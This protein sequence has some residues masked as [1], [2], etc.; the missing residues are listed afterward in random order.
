MRNSIKGQK[1]FT[2]SLVSPSP[3]SNTLPR[4]RRPSESHPS[5]HTGHPL[6]TD[7]KETCMVHFLEILN[8]A[9]SD[10][11]AHYASHSANLLQGTYYIN[12]G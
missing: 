8:E 3:P 1:K 9:K 7:S 4:Y 12:G 10:M 6:G 2:C 5:L 11:Y